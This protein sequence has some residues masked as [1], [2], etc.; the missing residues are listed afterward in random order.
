MTS[1]DPGINLL[2][3]LLRLLSVEGTQALLQVIRSPFNEYMLLE[4]AAALEAAPYER[5]CAR[6]G[7]VNGFNPKTIHAPL[8]S[9]CVNLQQVR[10]DID[11]YTSAL[12]KLPDW[13]PSSCPSRCLVRKGPHRR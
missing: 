7:Y 2:L 11:F 1:C 10:G 13:R 5:T 9:I 8:G 4:R 12:E 3:E 6:K